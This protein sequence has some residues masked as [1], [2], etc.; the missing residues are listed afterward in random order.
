LSRLF[1]IVA[2]LLILIGFAACGGGTSTSTSSNSTTNT[3]KLTFTDATHTTVTLSKPPKR[4]ACLVSICED[5]LA[6][7]GLDPVAVN[8]TLGQDPAFFGNKAK[9]FTFIGGS[10]FSPNIEDIAKANPD[11]VIGLANVDENL[12]DALKP[13]AP[14][15][16][17]NPT[18][19]NDSLFYLKDIGRLTGRTA[20]ANKAA[21]NFL[22]KLA[23]YKAKSPKNRSL[24]LIYGSDVN[25]NIFTSASL[26]GSVL[27]QVT[28]YPWPAPGPGAAPASDHE[29]GAM[30]YSLEKILATNPD[31]IFVASL[32]SGSGTVPLSKQLK[33]NPVWSHL[34]AVKDNQVYEV[35]PSYYIFGRGTISLGLALS[36]AMTKLY[37]TVFP[38]PL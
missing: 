16:I 9:N 20:Q 5:I 26:P 11:L 32:T 10:F 17:M 30:A 22:S 3:A 33:S 7:I 4:I 35:N 25:F 2:V 37:P 24:L 18:N 27:S 31:V 36:D 23:A 19:Y 29:P 34:K 14:L 1:R 6:A 28:K 12:R 8:D 13:I 38:R 15:Y 21:Q